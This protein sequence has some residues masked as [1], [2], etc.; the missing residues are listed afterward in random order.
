[1]G[2]NGSI[3][4]PRDYARTPPGDPVDRCPGVADLK[5]FG[6]LGAEMRFS[7]PF[8][9]L[10]Q[11]TGESKDAGPAAK[12]SNLLPSILLKAGRVSTRFS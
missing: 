7:T 4:K 12:R 8:K 3:K 11:N 10:D 9:A 1:M 5:I 6:P 2:E